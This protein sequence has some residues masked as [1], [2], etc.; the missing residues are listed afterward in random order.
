MG[1]F[2]R[3]GV[4]IVDGRALKSHRGYEIHPN[5]VA[6]HQLT[7]TAT[8][9]KRSN[10]CFFGDSLFSGLLKYVKGVHTLKYKSVWPIAF[11][12]PSRQA[13]DNWPLHWTGMNYFSLF[14]KQV[15]LDDDVTFS[16]KFHL[17]CFL[18]M[19]KMS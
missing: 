8:Q 14:S 3:P 13:T 15:Y 10:S 18:D 9:N 16:K 11:T 2:F 6:R 19:V 1:M 17:K 4:K 7:L 12:G 5:N